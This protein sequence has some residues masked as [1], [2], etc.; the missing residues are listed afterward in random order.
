MTCLPKWHQRQRR[1]TVL[2]KPGHYISK[3][4]VGWAALLPKS[5]PC[6][7]GTAELPLVCHKC[8]S[9]QWG[10]KKCHNWRKKA[11]GFGQSLVPISSELYCAEMR[12]WRSSRYRFWGMSWSQLYFVAKNAQ[13]M[14]GSSKSFV[15]KSSKKSQQGIWD[16]LPALSFQR[17]FHSLCQTSRCGKD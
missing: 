15:P 9:Q 8:H 7:R 5:K 3:S 1:K 11:E 10:T 17:S 12:M 6:C 16:V 2:T 4:G 14:K 13:G